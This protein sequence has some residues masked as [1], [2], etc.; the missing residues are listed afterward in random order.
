MLDEWKSRGLEVV[1]V[2]KY[3]GFYKTEQ[4][5]TPDQ[6]YA[7][8]ADF[9][10]EWSLPWPIVFGT[11]NSNDAAYGVNGIPEYVVIGRDGKIVS[12][13][14]GY[15]EGLHEELRKRIDEALGRKE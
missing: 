15:S 14:V 9:L 11:D 2:T 7:R 13:T 8:M 3:Y 6:E 5:L 1:A 10:K 12:V 4:K